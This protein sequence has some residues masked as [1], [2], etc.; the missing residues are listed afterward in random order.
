[1]VVPKTGW[2]LVAL[3]PKETLEREIEPIRERTITI[4]VMSGF[5]AVLMGI[6]FSHTMIGRIKR[7]MDDMEEFQ[8]GNLKV[9]SDC[10]G[11]DEITQLNRKFN[12]MV[13]S[14]QN[15]MSEMEQMSMVDGL[16]KVYNHK[17]MYDRLDQ[18]IQEA[19]RYGKRLSVVMVDIDHFKKV[20]DHYGHQVGD[21]VLSELAVFIKNSLRSIDIVGRYGGEEFMVILPETE[22]EQGHMVADKIRQRVESLR[23]EYEDL[24]ITI[25]GGVTEWM[26]ESALELVKRADDLLYKA[27][28]NGRNRMER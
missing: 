6:F 11:N 23:W 16:T 19:R 13:I 14:L 12:H 17:Y 28:N 1:M 24:K 20:N 4:G 3:I 10:H 27:K 2:K 8:K 25:S 26:E 18:E 21:Y 5:L 15:A 22:L 7:I 9:Q